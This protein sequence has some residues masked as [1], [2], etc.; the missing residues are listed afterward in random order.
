[1]ALRSRQTVML[2]PMRVWDAP[3]R[4]CH[5]LIVVLIPVSYVSVKL[6]LPALHM[7]LGFAMMALL[8]FRLAWGCIGSDAARFGRFLVNPF[9]GL[10]HLSRP[11][12]REVDTSF[13]HDAAGGWLVLIMLLLLAVQVGSGLF[14]GDGKAAAGPLAKY[15]DTDASDR[16]T[17]L[18]AVS[19]KLIAAAILLHV[20]VIGAY[21]FGKR[22]DLL[23]PMIT[24]KKRLPAA[25]R[26]PRLA[27]PL[28]ALLIL[29]LAVAVAV[30][31]AT[32]T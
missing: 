24:G 12:P 7:A 20:A 19:F 3:I 31:V 32:E 21:H 27:S 30:L 10:R 13:G 11:G 16:L 28:L 23:R 4:L 29:V 17:L 15:L 1:M 18:H 8:L 22:Q 5:W 9:A 25:T 2:L 14:A 6:H 26:A